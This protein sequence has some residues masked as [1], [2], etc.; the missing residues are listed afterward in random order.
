M[1]KNLFSHTLIYTISGIL[2]RGISFL[3]LPILARSISKEEFAVYD[4]LIGLGNV[5]LI[6]IPLEITQG[7]ARYFN[8]LDNEGEQ[9]AYSSTVL[10]FT[11]YIHIPVIFAAFLFKENLSRLL[12]NDAKFAN[13]VFL[14]A[15]LYATNSLIY[16]LQN[17]FRWRVKP[18]RNVLIGLATSGLTLGLIIF[19]T[20]NSN[21]SLA[22]IIII[23][24]ISNGIGIGLCFYYIRKNWSPLFD[25]SILKLLLK[26]SFPL[27]PSSLAV[28]LA[29]YVDRILI[30]R[31][32]DLDSL[33][34]YGVG[35]RIASLT[36]LCFIGVQGALTPLI[37]KH[38]KEADTANKIA[39]LFQIFIIIVFTVL[40]FTQIFIKDIVVLVASSKYINS[41]QISN[42]LIFSVVFWQLYIFFPGLILERKTKL[43][44]AI[45]IFFSFFNLVLNYLFIQKWGIIGSG[46]ATLISSFCFAGTYFFVS[47]K[48]YRLPMKTVFLICFIIIYSFFLV[49]IHLDWKYNY[50]TN[51]YLVKVIVFLFYVVVLF[52][53]IRKHSINIDFK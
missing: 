44:A 27:V 18:I 49:F 37:L 33:A 8:E 15:I 47:Q 50:I 26:F 30:S 11:I 20:S 13:E 45:N 22:M 38:Y 14:S 36:S 35:Y 23:L 10:N 32:L 40:G 9:N 2:T 52:K 48:F 51:S 34:V 29:L 7:F 1:F 5:L 12:F 41:W 17:E 6:L 39:N 28:V 42:L 43:I 19:Y 24:I 31:L 25:L 46:V 16:T 3:L 4:Y 21:L 53:L